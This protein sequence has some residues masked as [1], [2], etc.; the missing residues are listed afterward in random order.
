MTVSPSMQLITDATVAQYIHE[1]SVRHGPRSSEAGAWQTGHPR[2]AEVAAI[3]RS[4]E[5]QTPE[6]AAA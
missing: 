4:R 2:V 1:I 3:R 5:R 6:R